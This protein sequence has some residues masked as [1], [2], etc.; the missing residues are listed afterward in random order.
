MIKKYNL[1]T[2]GNRLLILLITII[3]CLALA[4]YI[5]FIRDQEVVYT[6]FFYIPVILAGLWYHRKAV[7]FALFLGTV[8]IFIT[9]LSDQDVTI[10]NFGRFAILIV[11]AYVIG[12]ISEKQAKGEEALRRFSKELELK[13]EER[14]KELK[15]EH[16]YTRHLIESSPDFQ[17]TLDRDGKIMDVN[18]AFEKIIDKNRKDV[19]GVSIYEYFPREE[20]EKL[21]SEIFEKKQVRDIELTV[22]IPKKGNLIC[23]ISGTVFTTPERELRIYATGRDVTEIKRLQEEKLKAKDIQLIHAARLAT[24][25]EMATA[26]A[27]EI[28]QPLTI[29]SLAAEGISRDIKKNRLDM[30]LIPND[31][32]D[33]LNNVNRIDRII[34]HM[35]TFA[36]QPEELESTEPEKLINNAFVMLGEQLKIHNITVSHKIEKNLPVIEVDP[37]QLEQVF[38]NILIN[39]RQVL[40]EKEEQAN[41]EGKSFQKQLVC[42]IVREND[43][44]VFEFADNACGVPDKIKTRIFEPFFTTRDVGQGTGLGLSIAYNI[45]TRSLSGKIWVENN[46]MGGASF[47]VAIPIGDRK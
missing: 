25:G 9:Y 28:N 43:Y 19:I 35:R 23:N 15:K 11:V 8:H 7:Y 16:D 12:L 3:I 44:V 42:S 30:S 31:I 1:K 26:M 20:T 47:K 22:N 6:Q 41:I 13:V 46:K 21:I 10:D 2:K 34:S 4:F 29:I 37:N 39:A 14:T 17:M 36:R 5:G 24:L 27:H 40:D 33:V 18:D 38:I 32:Q 45:V